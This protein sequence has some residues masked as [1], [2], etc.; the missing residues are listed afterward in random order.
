MSYLDQLR[1]ISV[2]IASSQIGIA[3]KGLGKIESDPLTLQLSLPTE[4][5]QQTDSFSYF[6]NQYIMHGISAAKAATSSFTS[7]SLLDSTSRSFYFATRN[8]YGPL[9]QKSEDNAVSFVNYYSGRSDTFTNELR[10][11][12]IIAI[13]MVII[14]SFIILPVVFSINK[15]AMQVLS[16]FGYIPMRE[17]NDMIYKCEKYLDDNLDDHAQAQSSSVLDGEED[18]K[19]SKNTPNEDED[20][21]ENEME[22]SQNRGDADDASLHERSSHKMETSMQM[23]TPK[24]P[25]ATLRSTNRDGGN[26]VPANRP[27]IFQETKATEVYG[28]GTLETEGIVLRT[29]AAVPIMNSRTKLVNKE[30]TKH[31]DQE[32]DQEFFI[33][34]SQKLMDTRANVKGKVSIQFLLIGAAFVAYFIGDYA[35]CASTYK[36]VKSNL[37]YLQLSSQITP[38]L[39]L[40]N[41]FT[42]EEIY[43]GGT[44]DVYKYPSNYFIPSQCLI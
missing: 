9:R 22:A 10:V 15:T 25:I 31:Y 34:R 21:E 37:Y 30:E 33:S 14:S 24:N 28:E 4:I 41:A 35:H 39:R 11:F 5:R 16:L 6:M 17:I 42:L 8:G 19:H 20:E 12:M 32:E 40:I 18:N 38:D 44:N 1:V 23:L 7:N 36:Q 26:R 2:N 13:I 3:N 29:E 27:N 43:A